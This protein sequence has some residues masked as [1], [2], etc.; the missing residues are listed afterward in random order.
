MFTA[1][2]SAIVLALRIIFTLP[3]ASFTIFTDSRSVLSALRCSSP[4][5]S[6]LVLSA[7][8]WLYLLENRGYHIGFCWVP[9]HVGVAGNER[10]DELAREAAARVAVPGT[11]PCADVFP[12]IKVAVLAIWQERGNA[13]GMIS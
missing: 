11:V 7:L 13:Q 9:G 1:E 8:E 2:L 6:P 4:S 5:V 12:T 10:A 3:V